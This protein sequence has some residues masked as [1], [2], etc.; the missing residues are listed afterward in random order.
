MALFQK[1][2]TQKR[3]DTD[4]SE[5]LL[6]NTN[7]LVDGH[8][9]SDGTVIFYYADVDNHK[10]K[11]I[12]YHCSDNFDTFVTQVRTAEDQEAD[13]GFNVI[14]LTAENRGPNQETF[15]KRIFFHKDNFVK[16]YADPDDSNKSQIF[17]AFG[18]RGLIQYKVDASLAEIENEASASVSV[19]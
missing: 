3:R 13:T 18:G 14:S 1:A 8:P 4:Y 17:L 6:L 2:V 19:A 16:G 10:V 7:R 15:A 12:E 9:D 5:T 11:P